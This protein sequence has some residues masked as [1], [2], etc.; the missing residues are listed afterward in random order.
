MPNVFVVSTTWV[1]SLKQ[2]ASVT[3]IMVAV[4]TFILAARDH[5]FST[6]ARFPKNK[7]FLPL[8]IHTYETG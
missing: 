1:T 3:N 4:T 5:L 2:V 7:H 8:D 6:C